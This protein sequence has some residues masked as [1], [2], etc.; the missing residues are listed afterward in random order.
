LVFLLFAT[1]AGSSLKRFSE[2]KGRRMGG[3]G[4]GREEGKARFIPRRV[5][6]Q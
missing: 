5:L 1:N 4:R 2:R 3:E 6:M